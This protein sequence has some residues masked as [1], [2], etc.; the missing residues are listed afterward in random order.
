[1]RNNL[2]H[3][4]LTVV[5][6][7]RDHDG[8]EFPLAP[9]TI[10]PNEVKSVDVSEA[11]VKQAPQLA[12]SY[13]SVVFRYTSLFTK[14]LYAAVMVFDGGHP[15]AFH[16]DA[17]ADVPEFS[18]GS[19]EGVWWLP[20]ATVR[21]YLVLTNKSQRPLPTTLRLYDAKGKSFSQPIV[22]KPRSTARFSVRELLQKARLA[23]QYGGIEIEAK[24]GVGS[25]DTTHVMFDETAGFSA[26]MKMF[27]RDPNEQV[28]PRSGPPTEEDKIWTTRAPMLALT[29]PDAALG[30]PADTVLQPRIFVRNTTSKAIAASVRFNWRSDDKSGSSNLATLAVAAHGT[31]LVDISALQKNKVIPAEAHWASVELSAPSQP[32]DLVAVAASYDASLRHGTQTPFNDTLTYM[33]EGGHWQ[34][35]SNHDSI[36][37]AGNGGRKAIQARFTLYYDEGRQHYD[38]EQELKPHEQMWIEVGKLIRDRIAD[39]NGAVLPP[40]LTM[41]AYTFQDLT[42]QGVG[43]LFEGKVILDRTFGQVAYGCAQCCGM[44][45]APFMYYDPIGVAVSFQGNQDVWDRDTCT[46]Q[47][48][49]V[50]DN[51]LNG[52][53]TTDNSAIATASWAVV[54]G[55][56]AGQ[57]NHYAKGPEGVTV[58][59]KCYAAHTGTSGPVGVEMFSVA[60]SS[61]IP[62]DHVQ[63]PTTSICYYQGQPHT[64]IYMGDANRNTYRTTES[65]VV[66]PDTQTDS[67]F[68][69][70]TGATKNYGAGSPA[71]GSTLSAADED[72][73]A[74][75]CHL[76][77]ASGKANPGGFLY[78][79][80]FPYAHQGQVH[81]DG[82]SSNPL[83]PPAPILWD[84]RTVID[85]TNPAAPTAIVNYNH[86]CY[87]SHQIKVNE[88]VVYLYTPPENDAAY[89]FGCLTGILTKISG[90]QTTPTPVPQ[91]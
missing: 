29:N 91:Y 53:W 80:S 8:A 81:F 42:D 33:W 2:A 67:G 16:M 45:G 9:V 77:N 56:G 11:V 79:V 59:N 71:N 76:W 24:S 82:S 19:R 30:F 62:V 41:G 87:P 74:N 50:L 66:V 64:R 15:I 54:T 58:G 52:N 48:K 17:F 75:D 4:D 13:G 57:T 43:N 1:M 35:D 3:G 36:I 12:G 84:M 32:N 44:A 85:T 49:S 14:N 20:S 46:G 70:N 39:K 40:G 47:A 22:L 34:A 18:A 5:P 51:F 31:Q 60:Y 25:L 37:T 55:V 89:I 6:V 69:P 73:I 10:F 27:D 78:D 26:L 38:L 88:K 83:E 7:L 61:Y 86:T 21:D 68:F 28:A 90:H 63:G 23:G 72:G 65:I